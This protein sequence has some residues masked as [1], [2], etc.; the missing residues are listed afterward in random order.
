MDLWEITEKRI[1]ILGMEGS[2]MGLTAS[3]RFPAL[4][5]RSILFLGAVRRA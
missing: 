1:L 4:A 3:E 2:R 5:A